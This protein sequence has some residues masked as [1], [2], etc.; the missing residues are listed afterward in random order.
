MQ[1]GIPGTNWY[2]VAGGLSVYPRILGVG[3][4]R[5]APVVS[6]YVSYQ[7]ICSVVS[8]YA[9]LSAHMLSY[10]PIVAQLLLLHASRLFPH[11]L[12]TAALVARLGVGVTATTAL[13]VPVTA[14]TTG[15]VTT[16]GPGCRHK[17]LTPIHLGEK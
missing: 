13:T 2:T 8:P 17:R 9:Q 3:V 14:V 16:T 1:G 10:Q 7:P 6:P 12:H 4:D 5:W 11:L 15:T